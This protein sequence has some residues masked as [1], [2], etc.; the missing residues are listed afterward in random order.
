MFIYNSLDNHLIRLSS[1]IYYF[2]V[3]R[4]LLEHALNSVDQEFEFESNV[5]HGFNCI[6]FLE[7]LSIIETN[8][9]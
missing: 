9:Y 4:I 1:G 6:A 3:P 2:F 7:Q 8:V 5:Q